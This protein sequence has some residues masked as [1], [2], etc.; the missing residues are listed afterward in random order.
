MP[1][2]TYPEPPPAFKCGICSLNQ[3]KEGSACQSCKAFKD[4][5]FF[6]KPVGDPN[7]D[8]LFIG[9]GPLVPRLTLLKHDREPEHVMFADVSGKIIQS[10]V[11][12]LREKSQFSNIKCRYVY[13]VKCAVHNITKKIIDSCNNYLLNEIKYIISTREQNNKH[14]N[15]IIV[16]HGANA[17]R[18][19]RIPVKSEAES[20]GQIYE[21][22]L[23]NTK[24]TV[25]AS[26]SIKTIAATPGK[27]SS[28][29]ADIERAF[30][31][32]INKP[33]IPLAKS[34]LE[35]NYI[36]PKTLKEVED[37][38]NF[39][40]NYTMPGIP[41]DEYAI[42]VDTETNTLFPHRDGLILTI[43]SFAWGMGKA[44]AIPL[45]HKDCPYDP[46]LAWEHVV[47]VLTSNKKKIL[48]HGKYDE[49]V[50]WKKGVKLRRFYW[51]VMLAEHG[52]E[53][54][55]KG[56]YNLKYLT[57][58]Y[59]PEYAGYEDQLHEF[60]VKNEGEKQLD[61][62]R[63]HDGVAQITLPEIV[64]QSLQ[65]IGY[66]ETIDIKKFK[67]EVQKKKDKK[68]KEDEE[69]LL[70]A[71]IILTY[72]AY[73]KTSKKKDGGF[74]K[75][76]L[77]HEDG[78]GLQ[79]F[80]AAVDADVTRQLSIKQ[81]NRMKE[82]DIKNSQLRSEMKRLIAMEE[83]R[84]TPKF[85][86]YDICTIPSPI[87]NLSKTFYIN[88]STELA[89]IEYRGVKVDK[90]FIESSVIKLK[91]IVKRETEKIYAMAG[92]EFKIGSGKKVASFL[93]DS[94][95][96]YIPSDLTA[97]QELVNKYPNKMK[98]LNGRLM[99]K[100]ISYT[101][102]GMLQ[103]TEKVLR[104][105]AI[106][107]KCEFANSLILLRKADRAAGTFL[108]NALKLS[109]IDGYLHTNYN[110]TGTAT[111]RLSSNDMNMQNI[112]KGDM[113]GIAKEDPRYKILSKKEREG[114][115][116]KK[117][118]IPDT[119]GDVFVNADAK[120]AEVKIF[121]AYSKDEKLIRALI[122]G[123]DAHSFFSSKIL[124]PDTVGLGLTGERRKKALEAVGI[125][126]DHAW[127]YEDFEKR[128]E[129]SES[130]DPELVAY[131]KRLKAHRDNVKRVVFG[132]LF[133]AGP[134]KIAEI[135]GI[136]VSLAKSI[137][138]L[139]FQMFP[140]IPLFIEQTKWELETFGLVETYFGRK[141]RFAIKNAPKET[142]ARAQRQAVNFKIQSTNS[143]IVLWCLTEMAP[144]IR[145]DF[146][147]RILL[148]VHDSIGFQVKKQYVSQLKDFVYEY[149]T[150]RVG[151]LCPWLPMEFKWDIQVGPSYGEL[152]SIDKYLTDNQK[153]LQLLV[154]SVV[155]EEILHDLRLEG[156][157]E[158]S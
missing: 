148:T 71:E 111:S 35:K 21:I 10:A 26:S 91:G 84:G 107:Y 97:A 147:G 4:T 101:E 14:S 41:S 68:L 69:F 104:T 5:H 105:L 132:I 19:L 11:L 33:V 70:N 154:D 110:Q 76:P 123:L 59:L 139:L 65:A 158:A 16:A 45:W 95:F 115:N 82:E 64:L 150:K 62:V 79:L 108:I 38:C 60:L 67:K 129:Y 87:I 32:V 46:D 6:A 134:R 61:N 15:L 54:D 100:G 157:G 73:F 53:E 93:F 137:I 151:K 78:T 9:D 56:Q 126:D 125:D 48:F 20:S 75:I 3:N 80:Y 122:E 94:G 89:D 23:N 136:E 121:A 24:C 120:G 66:D 7:C 28:L 30:N 27:Y 44:C 63:K 90:R 144:V 119:D 51:D 12:Q 138:D 40:L 37:L 106:T 109:S 1:T 50:F 124:S 117:I 153:E 57:K 72:E 149:G 128:D 77:Y 113:G 39:I 140:T 74:E 47:R 142:I 25:I 2:I 29:V 22:E 98:I 31:I 143:D 52:L 8:V 141:R 36:Y 145:N 130:D 17:L 55:K 34:I 92:E 112:P 86:V 116:C 131:G 155:E 99:Y 156:E 83:K 18:A 96:G 135:V 49:K 81:H 88:R 102:K 103:T 114:V 58:Q 133:G 42:A 152:F 118:F 127:S 13:A 146:K 85:R 43:V